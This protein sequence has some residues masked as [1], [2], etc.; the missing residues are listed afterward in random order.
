M[1]THISDNP[2]T[3]Q[4]QT[5]A[6]SA[7]QG[8][9]SSPPVARSDGAQSEQQFRVEQRQQ[10]RGGATS[11][12]P[13]SRPVESATGLPHS[14]CTVEAKSDEN[15]TIGHFILSIRNMAIIER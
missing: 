13:A 2:N 3:R 8:S 1:V 12:L 6:S 10:R 4:S 14:Y 15:Q 9:S 5:S 7:F 11:P